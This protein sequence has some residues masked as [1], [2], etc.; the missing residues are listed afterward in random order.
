MAPAEGG[1]CNRK[2]PVCLMTNGAFLELE[3]WLE[4]ATC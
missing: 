3:T 4:H 2:N 1:F